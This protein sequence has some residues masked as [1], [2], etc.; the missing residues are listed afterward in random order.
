V[1]DV[2]KYTPNSIANE[3]MAENAWHDSL[4]VRDEDYEALRA[5][6]AEARRER[7]RLREALE[8][9]QALVR[10]GGAREYRLAT[11]LAGARRE[12]RSLSVFATETLENDERY[13]W[14]RKHYASVSVG[15][16]NRQLVRV[17]DD[18]ESALDDAIDAARSNE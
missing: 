12:I 17:G 4:W 14:L 16:G 9:T 10:D 1:S 15:A 18:Y 5:E 13:R 3:I 11:E 8:G 6:L 7:D 2:K